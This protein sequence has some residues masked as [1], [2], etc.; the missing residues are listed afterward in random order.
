MELAEAVPILL[1]T[2]RVLITDSDQNVQADLNLKLV[3]YAD[4]IQAHVM[5]YFNQI[6][7]SLNHSTQISG[8]PCANHFHTFMPLFENV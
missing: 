5:T 6:D 7:D 1:A 2:H 4:W 3:T 8:T